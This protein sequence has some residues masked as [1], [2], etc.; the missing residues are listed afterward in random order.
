M[1]ICF[2]HHVSYSLALH[3]ILISVFSELNIKL[4][5]FAPITLRTMLKPPATNSRS[6]N[7]HDLASLRFRRLSNYRRSCVGFTWIKVRSELRSRAS[8]MVMVDGSFFELHM[9]KGGRAD[10]EKGCFFEVE[11]GG[12]VSGLP[13]CHSFMLKFALNP[14]RS[15]PSPS[16]FTHSDGWQCKG[17]WVYFRIQANHETKRTIATN[18]VPIEWID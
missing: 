3:A 11:A 12:A 8:K 1:L 13:S 9:T 6:A 18:L 7:R 15:H 5:M 17:S 14:V 2:P 4:S 10:S 16:F